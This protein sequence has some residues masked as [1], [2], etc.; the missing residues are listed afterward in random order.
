LGGPETF[1]YL[2]QSGCITA[3]HVDDVADF[4]HV[5]HAMKTLN[6]SEEVLSFIPILEIAIYSRPFL[7]PL[8]VG[9]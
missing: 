3:D 4:A 5:I 2:N 6:F 8:L 9:D 1:N 7:F